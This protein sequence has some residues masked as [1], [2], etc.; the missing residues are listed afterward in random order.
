MIGLDEW[1][2]D[3][4]CEGEYINGTNVLFQVFFIGSTTA[5]KQN[6]EL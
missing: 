4:L 1:I 3:T 2:L 5:I 6:C